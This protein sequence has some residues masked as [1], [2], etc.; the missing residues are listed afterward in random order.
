MVKV[1]TIIISKN[2]ERNIKECLESVKWTDEIIVIDANSQDRTVA[3]A[4]EFTDKVFIEEWKGYGKAKNFALSKCSNDWVLWLDADERVTPEL[5]AEIETILST[6]GSDIAAFSIPRR[7]N[8]LGKWVNHCGWYPARVIRLFRRNQSIFTEEKVH[9]Q[10]KI[11]GKIKLLKS[12]ILHYTDPSLDHYITKLNA[13][14]T[15]SA[16]ELILKNRKFSIFKLIF[17]PVWTFI[18]M[19]FIKLGIL[20]GIPGL[21]LCVLSANHVFIKYSKLWELTKAKKRCNNER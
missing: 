14:T 15:L 1:S 20:D 18:R 2:E 7:A 17:N 5:K 16:E 21:I 12:D 11:N 9:E 6:V 4:K 3:I 8:F 19:Y 10:L 13:Y